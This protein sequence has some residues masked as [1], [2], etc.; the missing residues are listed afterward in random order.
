[1]NPKKEF[2]L[3]IKAAIKA[4]DYLKKH[5]NIEVFNSEGKD[6]KLKADKIAEQKII[7]ILSQSTHNIISEESGKIKLTNSELCWIVDPLDGS[8]NFSR[9]IPNCAVSIALYK[10]LEPILGVVYDFNRGELF[11][12]VVGEGAWL[13]ND[14]IKVSSTEKEGNAVIYT[15]FPSKSDYSSKNISSFVKKVQ[16]F[17]KV[18]LLGSAALSLAYVSCGRGDIYS[19]KS[20]NLWDVAAG[21][22]IVK[23][24]GGTISMSKLNK[25]LQLDV[26]AKNSNL[27]ISN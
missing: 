20:I 14:K 15:G 12:G 27:K 13:N 7:E 22:A 8:L 26:S 4:G 24:A 9:H 16:K 25:S 6:V 11:K 5:D 23:A 3:A 17:K 2:E 1:M 21:L 10:K 19:E 18:R